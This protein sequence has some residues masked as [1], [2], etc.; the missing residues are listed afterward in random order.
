[1]VET[2]IGLRTFTNR[3]ATECNNVKHDEDGTYSLRMHHKPQLEIV[4]LL[5]LR[6][7]LLFLLLFGCLTFGCD[8]FSFATLL[9]FLLFLL[10]D[11]PIASRLCFDSL[12]L[13]VFGLLL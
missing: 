2:T 11:F 1:M 12:H 8:R 7:F 13:A 4:T 10:L 5:L 3:G 9:W 6:L